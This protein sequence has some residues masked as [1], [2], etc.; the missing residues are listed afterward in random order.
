M[1]DVNEFLDDPSVSQEAKGRVFAVRDQLPLPGNSGGTA[2][3]TNKEYADR[4]RLTQAQV[5]L[6]LLRPDPLEKQAAAQGML[7]T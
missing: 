4:Y 2:A 7:Q 1:I 5:L 6:E 3:R